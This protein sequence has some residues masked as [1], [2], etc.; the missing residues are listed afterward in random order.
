MFKLISVLVS[1]AALI[2]PAQA[3]IVSDA[4]S[5][6]NQTPYGDPATTKIRTP[7]PNYE[8][9]F[10]ENVG[11]HGS[12]SQTNS[13]SEKRALAVW[14]A[15]AKKGQLTTAGKLFDDDLKAF[16]AA[17]TTIGY[18]HLSTIGRAEWAGIGRRTAANYHD[19]LTKAAADGDDIRFRTTSIYRTQQSATALRGGLKAAIPGLDLKDRTTDDRMLITN[20]ATAKGNAAIASVLRRSDVRTAARHVLR[21]LYTASYVDSLSDPVGKALDIYGMY[22]LAA[23]MH[24]DTDVTFSRYVPLTDAHYLGFAKDAQN[25][26]RYGPG[27]KGETSSYQQA[28][29]ILTD[30]FSQLDKRIA[31][32]STAAVFRLAH[33]ETTMPFAALTRLPGSTKQASAST[34]YSYGNNSWRG[35]VAGRM[36]G[37]IEWVAYRNPKS[38]GVL[39]TLRY[40]EQ[41]VRLNSSCTP[42][43]LDPYFYRVSALKRCL[44]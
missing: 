18:G 21:R 10:I 15:A 44:L 39:V 26:Y 13:D 4:H 40:N 33:G 29:P 17:E 42:S 3:D 20:G 7:P 28:R 9:F 27:V 41:P 14:N 32:G 8:A 43:D 16:Q 24:D 2:G 22:A 23:G 34:P 36:A 12:R 38:G 30:F 25:F 19:L 37:N 11:R 5:Y 1:L 35:Y 31:G 6:S